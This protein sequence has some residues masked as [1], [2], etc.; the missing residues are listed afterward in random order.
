MFIIIKRIHKDFSPSQKGNHYLFISVKVNFN[1]LNHN[2]SNGL[3]VCMYDHFRVATL[4]KVNF[5][6][7]YERISTADGK[8]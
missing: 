4:I 5:I 1:S 2:Y 3:K 7:S 8:F 6:G